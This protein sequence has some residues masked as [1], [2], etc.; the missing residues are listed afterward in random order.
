MGAPLSYL[1]LA[2]R[3]GFVAVLSVVC[4]VL[5]TVIGKAISNPPA[6]FG[7]YQYSSVIGLTLAGVAAA[8]LVY[9][10]MRWY[11]VDVAK[12]NRYFLWLSAVV[13]IASFYPDVTMPWSNDPDQIGWTY[14]IIANLMLMHV[15]AGFAVMYFYTRPE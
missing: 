3:A 6:T 7:P 1:Q 9:A 5:L 2:R 13:L 4:N 12:T 8:A 15:I 11:L 10:A 14:G